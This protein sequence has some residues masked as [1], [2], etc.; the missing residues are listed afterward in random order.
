MND[1]I[2]HRTARRR[3]GAV[4]LAVASLALVDGMPVAAGSETAAQQWGAR[5]GGA[6]ETMPAVSSVMS[7]VRVMPTVTG[8]VLNTFVR[9]CSRITRRCTGYRQING[10]YNPSVGSHYSTRWVWRWI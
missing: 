5:R 2:A 4:A 6:V 9:D 1:R 7:S 10:P 3:L 8:V